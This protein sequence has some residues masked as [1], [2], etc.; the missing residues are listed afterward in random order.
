M[1]NLI[2]LSDE[3]DSFGANFTEE[4]HPWEDFDPL[5]STSSNQS[6]PNVPQRKIKWVLK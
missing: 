6:T 2:N 1:E 5:S 4:K 3:N